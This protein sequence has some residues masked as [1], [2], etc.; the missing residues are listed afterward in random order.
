ML[1]L[2]DKG[3]GGLPRWSLSKIGALRGTCRGRRGSRQR[4]SYLIERRRRAYDSF[5][6]RV[7]RGLGRLVDLWLRWGNRSSYLCLRHSLRLFFLLFRIDLTRLW[8]F[9]YMLL[10]WIMAFLFQLDFLKLNSLFCYFFGLCLSHNLILRHIDV[11]IR[12]YCLTNLLFRFNSLR[13]HWFF[14]L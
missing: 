11:W 13:Y 5:F 7:E 1:L 14:H 8:L 6:T 12:F 2:W 9:F 3:R 4:I 10:L